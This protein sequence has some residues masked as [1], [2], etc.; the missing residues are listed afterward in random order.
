MARD[1][2]LPQW[3]ARIHGKYRTP[4]VT[5]LITGVFVALWSLIGDAAETYDLTNIGT[6][7]AFIL[8]CIGVIV[9]RYTDPDRKRPFR[10]PFVHVVGI[11]GAGLCFF[12]M[13]GLPRLAWERFGWWL[14]IGLALYFV[15][16]YRHSTLRRGVAP[17]AP[18]SSP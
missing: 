9:L 6:L 15:Y 17:V 14:L 12:V 1:G 10:V 11:L 2:L 3:A 18:S 8:V 4:Y 7:F 5:T 16:G 13:R